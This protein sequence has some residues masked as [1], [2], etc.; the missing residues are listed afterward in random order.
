VRWRRSARCEKRGVKSNQEFGV[1]KLGTDGAS[2][3]FA[4]VEFGVVDRATANSS[5]QTTTDHK[6]GD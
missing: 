4:L 5:P 1:T 2:Q 3:A 6:Q